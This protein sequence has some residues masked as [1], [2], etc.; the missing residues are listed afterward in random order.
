MIKYG[1]PY[2]L[3]TGYKVYESALST[4]PY[5]A[6]DGSVLEIQFEHAATLI[7]VSLLITVI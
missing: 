1:N 3:Y 7:C 5:V 2:N 6:A 4:S